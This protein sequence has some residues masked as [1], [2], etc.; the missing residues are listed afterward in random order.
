MNIIKL[1]DKKFRILFTPAQIEEAV[2]GIAVKLNKD[3]AGEEPVFISVLN[4]SFMFTSDLLKRI[5]LNCSVSFLKLASYMETASTGNITE[6]IGLNENLTGKVVVILE[7]IVDTGTTLKYL[8]AQLSRQGPKSIKVATLLLK[9]EAFK[10]DI[11]IDYVGLEIPNDFIVG[12]GLDYNQLGRNYG[13]IY[14][15]TD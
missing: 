6:L 9:P 14:K 5:R 7:D 4:G 3:L 1:H 12:Y 10:G 2:D 13:S 15:I 8:V 11:D